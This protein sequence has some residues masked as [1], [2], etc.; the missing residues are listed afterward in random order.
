MVNQKG[1][2]KEFEFYDTLEIKHGETSIRT[3]EIYAPNILN[4]E[5]IK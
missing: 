3:F 5:E 4:I 1:F 2:Q